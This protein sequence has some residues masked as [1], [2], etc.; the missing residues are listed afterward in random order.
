MKHLQ[1]SQ[2][3]EGLLNQL[4]DMYELVKTLTPN[5]P[6]PKPNM[7]PNTLKDY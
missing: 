5:F 6:M 1:Y 3:V 7:L 2:N 4:N